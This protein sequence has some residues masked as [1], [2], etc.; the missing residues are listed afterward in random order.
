MDD[1]H[2]KRDGNVVMADYECKE[3]LDLIAPV[4]E[5]L[6][7][8]IPGINLDAIG[9][10]RLM[11]Q[12]IQ[13]M[14][15][16][17]G[18]NGTYKIQPKIPI[19][20]LRDFRPQGP[21]FELAS[22]L[23]HIKCSRELQNIDFANPQRKREN[24][25]IYRHCRGEL[26]KLKMILPTK[27]FIDP[28]CL[29]NDQ[30]RLRQSITKLGGQV[31]ESPEEEGL[32]HHV[33]PFP[34]SGDPDDGNIYLRVQSFRGDQAF[35]HWWYLPE[36]YDEYVPRESVPDQLQ[37]DVIPASG[38]WKVYLRWVYD[39]EKY[40]EW[41]NAADY[42]TKEAQDEHEQGKLAGG[43]AGGLVTVKLEEEA[44]EPVAPAPLPSEMRRLAAQM[45]P[46]QKRALHGLP[47][48]PPKRAKHV[49][50]DALA[51]PEVLPG[52]G[53][54]ISPNTVRHAL[55][56]PR[57]SIAAISS[58]PLE[59]ISQG[60]LIPLSGASH[61]YI[62][63]SL[64]GGLSTQLRESALKLAPGS[65]FDAKL[66]QERER[67]E[68]PEFFDGRCSSK[69]P[70]VYKEI[71]DFIV[72]KYLENPDHL[73]R[74]CDV[75]HCLT[76]DVNA[77]R[78]VFQFLERT[79]VINSRSRHIS[80]R[81]GLRRLTGLFG[82]TLFQ[83]PLGSFLGDGFTAATKGG[84]TLGL[85]SGRG[86]YHSQPPGDGVADKGF[87]C[88]CKVDLP[89]KCS[90]LRYQCTKYPG[91]SLCPTAFSDGRFPAG[92]SSKDFV[93]ASTPEERTVVD[94]GW[95]IQESALLLGGLEIFGDNWG[96]VA[97]HVGT[98]TQVQCIQQFIQMPIDDHFVIG[99]ESGSE[100]GP[101]K[102]PFKESNNPILAQVAFLAAML[103]PKVAAAS[104][105]K[106]LEALCNRN[107]NAASVTGPSFLGPPQGG[108]LDEVALEAL[109]CAVEKARNLA[110]LEHAELQQL[111]ATAL[112]I[113]ARRVEVKM[114]Q[115]DALDG[116]MRDEGC[117][118]G[119]EIVAQT[120]EH[121]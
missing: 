55:V 83:P 113:Q 44:K 60:Q 69:I 116:A 61:G 71:R 105:G 9:L 19:H 43:T 107:G 2:G 82:D 10:A 12:L 34:A 110:E 40:N 119:R 45:D 56:D 5:A 87:L 37:L 98:K 77:T 38:V 17:A 49:S 85:F 29:P 23:H 14:E 59:N 91:I 6:Q 112:D 99:M 84:S 7:R 27:V 96:L 103:S 47:G 48:H 25:E 81:L 97:G 33:F 106:A 15:E 70:T 121:S 72:N 32:T 51:G 108:V 75:R 86:P 30:T 35:V 16:A 66:I 36:S 42:E 93:L 115:L 100:S 54:V 117:A 20:L 52:G 111:A 94:S 80:R 118:L 65:W 26:E 79:G 24:L 62:M 95:T 64:Q 28:S 8:E 120:V 4:A 114:K 31:A 41:M 92:T 67:E 102:L 22:R 89:S 18:K 57:R 46:S 78:R 50:G 3:Y 13:F 73:L 109:A 11:A 88:T 63:E 68:L 53:E 76:G 21:I 74:H 1:P 58:L 101:T 39:S 90:D 104:A